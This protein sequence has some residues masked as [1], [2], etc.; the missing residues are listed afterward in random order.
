[1]LSE[2]GFL[3]CDCCDA[4]SAR[5]ERGWRAYLTAGDDEQIVSVVCPACAEVRVGENE[6]AWS[7]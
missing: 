2:A 4:A 3:Y 7:D 1:V 5:T 6:T